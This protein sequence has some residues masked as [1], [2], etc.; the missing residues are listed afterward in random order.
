MISV[1]WRRALAVAL[2]AAALCAGLG[3]GSSGCLN[4]CGSPNFDPVE[5]TFE[6][7][8]G[9]PGAVFKVSAETVEITY[10]LEDDSEWTVVYEVT[11]RW[12]DE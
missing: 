2:G 11:D 4:D 6:A 1:L 12:P 9:R 3:L 10:S 5:G 7:E 8:S